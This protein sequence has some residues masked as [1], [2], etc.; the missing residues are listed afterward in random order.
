GFSRKS[1][2]S[3]AFARGVHTREISKK[4]RKKRPFEAA[5]V[6]TRP[7]MAAVELMTDKPARSRNP[8]TKQRAWMRA[9]ALVETRPRPAAV[10]LM[11]DKPAHSR[12]PTTK[13][14]AWIRAKKRS[15]PVSRVL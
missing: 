9:M 8:T 4:S 2:S 5:F 14:R 13:Q 3:I 10:A 11:T 15:R 1:V 12:N 7:W 6:E